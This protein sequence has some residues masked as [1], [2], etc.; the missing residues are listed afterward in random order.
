MCIFLIVKN[1][2]RILENSL[3]V[4]HNTKQQLAHGPEIV[5]WGIYSQETE[6]EVHT[7]PCIISC[8][9]CT[10]QNTTQKQTNKQKAITN[11][12]KT[13][14]TLNTTLL[15]QATSWMNLQEIIRNEKSQTQKI[16]YCVIYV[17]SGNESFRRRKQIRD[18]QRLGM[19]QWE[20]KKGGYGYK[21]ATQGI[22]VGVELLSILTELVTT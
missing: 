17:T 16:T 11:T 15:I 10:P 20:R 8:G 19:Q 6:T 1:H 18:W 21:R 3:S 12:H 14:T 9:I 13:N 4:Y 22:L 2:Y 7:K 5:V